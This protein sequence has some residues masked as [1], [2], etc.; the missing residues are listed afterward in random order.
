MTHCQ[1]TEVQYLMK[2]EQVVSEAD[3]YHGDTLLL[4]EHRECAQQESAHQPDTTCGMQVTPADHKA[5]L[6]PLS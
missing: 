3:G 4:A 2:D 1:H 6:W 5:L